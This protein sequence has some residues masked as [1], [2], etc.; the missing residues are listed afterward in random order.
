MKKK[1]IIKTIILSAAF[2]TLTI[3]AVAQEMNAEIIKDLDNDQIA[4]TI[5]FDYEKLRIVCSLSSHNFEA[6]ESLPIQLYNQRIDIDDIKDGFSL[7]YHWPRHGFF[8]KFVYDTE[9]KKVCL[10][11]IQRYNL[12]NSR[13]IGEGQSLFRLTTGE[14]YGSW[15]YYDPSKDEYIQMPATIEEKISFPTV[16][17]EDFSKETNYAFAEKCLEVYRKYKEKALS[18]TWHLELLTT[19]LVKDLDYDQIADTVRFDVDKSVVICQLSTQN[20]EPIQSQT[21][22]NISVYEKD[23]GFILEDFSKQEAR[24]AIFHYDLETQKICLIE[25]NRRYDLYR[26]KTGHSQINLLTQD[27]TGVWSYFYY[28]AMLSSA[29]EVK[30]KIDYPTEYLEDFGESSFLNYVAICDKLFNKQKEIEQV[31]NKEI[32]APEKPQTKS[33]EIKLLSNTVVL[34]AKEGEELPCIWLKF[35]DNKLNTE[36]GHYFEIRKREDDF[37]VDE[38][39]YSTLNK[40][41]EAY[42]K[43]SFDDFYDDKTYRQKV[44][45]AFVNEGGL[46]KFIDFVNEFVDDDFLSAPFNEIYG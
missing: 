43:K 38:E 26:D 22:N 42:L 25:M 4:D 16:Y 34:E 2:F 27:Y 13:E 14:Y 45:E 31:K 8:N 35:T 18:G 12:D 28:G 20:F 44:W 36:D 7:E 37:F 24:Y 39:K 5:R 46:Q 15:D 30:A 41:V 23:N 32:R 40:A 11:E 9:A 17:L 6:I 3:N 21:I 1:V 33:I 29:F 19:M 10:T